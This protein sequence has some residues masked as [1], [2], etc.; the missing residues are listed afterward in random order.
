VLAL[1]A[2]ALVYHR[3]KAKTEAVTPT[4]SGDAIADQL[5]EEF[6]NG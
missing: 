3:F 2:L 1:V 6:K 5:E 4:G